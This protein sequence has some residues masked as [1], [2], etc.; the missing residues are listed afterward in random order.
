EGQQPGGHGLLAARLYT[1]GLCQGVLERGIQQRM[2]VRAQKHKEFACLACTRSNFLFFQGQ[3][4]RWVP[5]RGLLQRGGVCA[6]ATCKSTEPPV[7]STLSKLL[8]KQLI[9]VLVAQ[10][11]LTWQAIADFDT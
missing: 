6:S 10:L 5:Q 9:S 8:S 3:R 1:R 4:D 2:T 7:V 11:R